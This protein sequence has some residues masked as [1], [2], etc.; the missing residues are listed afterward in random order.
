MEGM[1]GRGEGGGNAGKVENVFTQG[2]SLSHS[3]ETKKTAI[4]KVALKNWGYAVRPVIGS[5]WNSKGN[6]EAASYI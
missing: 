5:I 2:T 4:S 3:G 1:E 6:C